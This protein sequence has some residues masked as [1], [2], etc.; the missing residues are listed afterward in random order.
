[1]KGRKR[2]KEREREREGRVENGGKA[3]RKARGRGKMPSRRMGL[4]EGK[5]RAT[6][7]GPCLIYLIVKS[8]LL[9]LPRKTNQ[10]VPRD[11][12]TLTV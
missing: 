2:D 4:V 9:F 8:W 11:V 12:I 5:D 1:M 10:E 3:K 7:M 6:V